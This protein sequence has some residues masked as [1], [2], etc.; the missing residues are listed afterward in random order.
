MPKLP[1]VSGKKA[2]KAFE[3]IGYHVVRQRGSHIRLVDS[4]N[5]REPLTIPDHAELGVGLLRKLIRNSKI[6]VE[7]F[8]KLLK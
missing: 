2:V 3:K 4:K 5:T 7:A 1:R 8:T 6:T